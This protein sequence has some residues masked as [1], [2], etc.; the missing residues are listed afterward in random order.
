MGSWGGRRPGAGAK[1]KSER[2]RA[3]SGARSHKPGRVLAHP[4][5]QTEDPSTDPGAVDEFDAPDDLTTDE[6]NV[7]LELAPFAF[8]NR[9]LTKATSL[10]FRMLCRNVVIEREMGAKVMDRGTANHRGMIQ[11]VDAELLRFNLSPCGKAMIDPK[12]VEKP[13]NP[14][15]KFLNRR[16]G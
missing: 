13:A 1:P 10:S 15:E 7:W 8:R 11:R 16:R 12:P 14:L 4:G 5:A 6:R 3:L 9:T 2:E